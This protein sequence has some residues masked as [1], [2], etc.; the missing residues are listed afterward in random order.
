M[1]FTVSDDPAAQEKVWADLAE[2][3]RDPAIIRRQLTAAHVECH[4]RRA[5]FVGIETYKAA[6]GHTALRNIGRG[7]G[8]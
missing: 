8:G 2:W 6:G 1:A 4:D 5:R 7:W 3:N